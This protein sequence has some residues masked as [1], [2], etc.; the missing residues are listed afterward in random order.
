MNKSTA[1]LILIGDELLHGDVEDSNLSYMAKTLSKNG[2]SVKE[3]SVVSDIEIDIVNKV[4]EF[5]KKYTYV[6]TTGGIGPTHDDITTASVAQ[7]FG[8]EV[9]RNKEAEKVMRENKKEVNDI[10]LRMADLPEGVTLIHNSI[11]YAPGFILENV[12]VL[13]GVPKIMQNMLDGVVEKIKTSIIEFSS[14]LLVYEKENSITRMLERTQSLFNNVKI[15]SYQLEDAA[16]VRLVFR[17]YDKNESASAISC[18]EKE[19][20]TKGIDY[21]YE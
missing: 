15:G 12:F 4:N 9:L 5:R 11:S 16:I 8:V 17:S 2:I 18:L 20:K 10:S 14:S 19:L 7:A 1:G 21:K 13:A 3:A 6:F